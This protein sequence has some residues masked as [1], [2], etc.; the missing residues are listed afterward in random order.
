MACE[1]AA[2][3]SRTH[4]PQRSIPFPMKK[5]SLLLVASFG[6]LF[7]G[8]CVYEERY[9]GVSVSRGGYAPGYYDDG[10]AAD[11]DYGGYDDGPYYLYGGR[12]YYSSGGRYRYYDGR[13]PVY[14]TTLPYGASYITPQQRYQNQVAVNRYKIQQTQAKQNYAYQQNQYRYAAK[15]QTYANQQKI[16][17][18]QYQQKQ[19]QWSNQQ[20][21]NQYQGQ[22]K[23]QQFANQQKINQY[24]AQQAAA[25]AKYK[26]QVKKDDN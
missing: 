16:Q 9:T 17:Q 24:Q 21:I 2:K 5:L 22:Q 15:S 6:A 11:V 12:R 1:E 10:Y 4:D 20:R 19:Q 8:G 26:K 3:V 13:R 18:Y 7:L 14:V 25:K 23:Q